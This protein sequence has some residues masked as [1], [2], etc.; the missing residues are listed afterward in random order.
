MTKEELTINHEEFLEIYF[1]V[2]E[3]LKDLTN[4]MP[5]EVSRVTVEETLYFLGKRAEKS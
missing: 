3:R 1:A 5:Q 2:K 4:W